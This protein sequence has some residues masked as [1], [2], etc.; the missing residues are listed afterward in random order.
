MM[1]L[2]FSP[3]CL[4]FSPVRAAEHC[5]APYRAPELF[6]VP[7]QCDLD[8][9]KCDVWS[10]GCLLFAMLYGYSPFECEFVRERTAAAA[11]ATTTTTTTTT[12]SGSGRG[13]G[14]GGGGAK[15]PLFAVR[16]VETSHLRVLGKVP[17]PPGDAAEAA[18][19]RAQRA[20][21]RPRMSDGERR[22]LHALAARLLVQSPND[23]PTLLQA[24]ALVAKAE[25]QLVG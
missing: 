19:Q 21:V 24:A 18:E 12:A 23:R 22:R 6:D 25:R 17:E 7:S 3:A 4:A 2:A 8:L 11:A 15:G 9:F 1:R 16:V 5:T 20:G 14:G 10:L 13:G